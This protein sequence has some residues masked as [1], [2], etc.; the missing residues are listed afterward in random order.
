[1]R[2][3][4]HLSIRVALA[5][6]LALA[7]TT[8]GAAVTF[9]T[10]QAGFVAASGATLQAT[11]DSYA[12]GPVPTFTQGSLTFVSWGGGLY[13]LPPGSTDSF[14]L[15]ATPALTEN[16]DED[17][18]I[19]FT[20]GLGQAIG[21]DAVSNRYNM[22]QVQVLDGSDAVL[23]SFPCGL[24][25]N[26]AGFIGIVSTTP[27]KTVRWTSDRGRMQDSYLDNVRASASLATPA[28]RSSWGRI[29]QL[30]R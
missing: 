26:T 4:L 5:A 23:A 3:L 21:F 19:Q 6:W 15:A 27:F 22:A 12:P 9:Y 11:F 24:A 28:T 16:G 10:N 14:P 2:S 29:K 1:M 8:A 20:T 30:F 25:P 7:A 13:I 18:L 17:I